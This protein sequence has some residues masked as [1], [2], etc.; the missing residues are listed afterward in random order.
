M[1]KTEYK[2]P[3]IAAWILERIVDPETGYTAMGDFEEQFYH[4]AKRKNLLFAQ[5]LYWIQIVVLVPSFMSGSM[6]RSF[7][8][9][10]NYF[11]TLIRNTLRQ[12]TYSFL[13]IFGL[14]FGLASVVIVFLYIRYELSFDTYHE[15]SDR[16][17]KVV[18]EYSGSS[19][20]GTNRF[21]ITPAPLAPALMEEFPEIEA[22]T[23]IDEMDDILIRTGNKLF[24]EQS[25]FWVDR[26]VFDVFTFPLLLGDEKTALSNPN[27]VIISERI[28]IKYFDGENP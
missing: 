9:L 7:C 11:K 15:N 5:T 8:M 4:N 20:R 6:Y 14:A 21:G 27:S 18:S 2:P 23:R 24:F 16:I 19:F 25:W 13:N 28:A 17:Y 22:A 1:K 10:K 3:K 12:K 26:Y